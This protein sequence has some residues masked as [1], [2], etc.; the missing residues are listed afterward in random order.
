M[1]ALLHRWADDLFLHGHDLTRWITDYVDI[2]ES[3]AVGSMA[4]EELAHAATLLEFAGD[5][6]DQRDWRLFRRPVA[7]WAPAEPFAHTVRDWPV[8]VARA[9]LFTAATLTLVDHLAQGTQGPFASALK[10]VRAEQELHARHWRRWVGVLHGET[11]TTDELR[12]ALDEQL[13]QSADLFGAMPGSGTSEEL[14]ELHDEWRRRVAET[15]EKCHV[16]DAELPEKP[17]A[18]SSRGP[19]DDLA[20]ILT[21]LRAV[22]TAN[23]D[24]NYEV[25]P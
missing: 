8:A 15:L 22:R 2:E 16:T 23:P 18:R 21:G 14:V 3:M 25:H 17:R 1:T 20:E 11:A 13:Q 6:P 9:V 4:Q 7:E 12:R 5:G 19:G 10:V 24:W